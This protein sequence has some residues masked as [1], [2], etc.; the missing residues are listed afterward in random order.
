MVEA[1]PGQSCHTTCPLCAS[2]IKIILPFANG[3]EK[4]KYWKWVEEVK[5]ELPATFM[6]NWRHSAAIIQ[7][8]YIDEKFAVVKSP[9]CF[10]CAIS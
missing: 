7:K 4:E 5:P 2:E 8:V 1:K 10:S 3:E 9:G 6:R